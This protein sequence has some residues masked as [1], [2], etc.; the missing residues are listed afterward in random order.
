MTPDE[1]KKALKEHA[2][3]Q[4]VIA[5]KLN[6]SEMSVSRVIYRGSTS[7]RIMRCIA[8]AIG[9]EHTAVFPDYYF[10]PAKRSTS[11][12]VQPYTPVKAE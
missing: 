8:K 11:K 7:D 5:K 2:T 6:V 10:S 9:K 3:T 12:T 1:I 4:K